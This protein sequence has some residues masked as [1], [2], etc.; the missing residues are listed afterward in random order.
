MM[1]SHTFPHPLV[2]LAF[3][4]PPSPPAKKASGAG[5]PHF[6]GF[7]GSRFSVHPAAGEWAT[8]L[9]SER[10]GFSLTA[11]MAAG[12]VSGSTLMH[13][14][15]F[16]SGRDFIKAWLEPTGR[17]SPGKWRLQASANNQA[18]TGNKRLLSGTTL[19]FVPGADGV[20]GRLIIDADFIRV[21]I[22]QRW[23]PQR[24]TLADFLDVNVDV[25]RP[26]ALTGILGPSYHRALQRAGAGAVAAAASVGRPAFLSAA[27][28]SD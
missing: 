18:V 11:L 21:A 14:F 27:S 24:D 9:A 25:K 1:E 12:P 20:H 22:I 16:R 2:L 8:V 6:R 10:Q 7:D 13:A 15:K 23:R 17:T 3:A 26:L 4:P 28:E 19:E 5:D